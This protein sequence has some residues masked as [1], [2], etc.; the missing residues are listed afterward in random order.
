MR[1]LI[2]DT[3]HVQLTVRDNE[4]GQLLCPPP[5]GYAVGT[6]HSPSEHN[7]LLHCSLMPKARDALVAAGLCEHEMTLDLVAEL[8]TRQQWEYLRALA[9]APGTDMYEVGVGIWRWARVQRRSGSREGVD[10]VVASLLQLG[11]INPSAR[12]LLR[13]SDDGVSIVTRPH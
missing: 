13:L 8:L 1:F 6:L 2:A 3:E 10:R 9:K 7:L 5:A 12:P 4:V 11:L